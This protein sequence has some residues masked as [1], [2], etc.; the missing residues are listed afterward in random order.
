MPGHGLNRLHVY[1]IDIGAFFSIHFDVDEVV[2][3]DLCCG[4]MLEALMLHDMTPVAG[5]IA[6]AEQDGFV[7]IFGLLESFIAPGEPIH[8]VVL[9]L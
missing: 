9:M 1:I 8:R 7:L 3:H 6:H 5:A 2:V 4:F